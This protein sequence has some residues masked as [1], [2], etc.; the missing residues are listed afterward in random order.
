MRDMRR[1]SR[2]MNRANQLVSNFGTAIKRRFGFVAD[3]SKPLWYNVKQ[4]IGE[5]TT[6]YFI[7]PSNMACHVRLRDHPTPKGTQSLLGLGLNYCIKEKINTTTE[8]T[9]TR[10][11]EDVRRIFHL[12]GTEDDGDYIKSLYIKSDYKFDEASEDIEQAL[13]NFE[14]AV[15]NDKQQTKQRRKVY[16][17]LTPYH[18]DLI[19]SLRNHDDYIIV[20]ADKNLGPCLLDRQ[21]YIERGCSEHLGNPTNYQEITEQQVFTRMAGLKYKLFH[22]LSEF[23]SKPILEKRQGKTPSV[24]AISKAE[25]T[26]LLRAIKKF[27]EKLARFRMTLKI[28]KIPWKTRPIVCCAGTWMNAWSKWLDYWLQ[29]LKPFVPTYTRDSQQLLDELRELDLPPNAILSTADA[30]AMYNNIDTEHAIQVITWWLD[31]LQPDL[32]QGFPIEAVKFAMEVIMRNN[33]FEWGDLYFL[34][35]LGTAMGT[36]AAVMWATLYYGY[37]EVHTL[38]PRYNNN[39]FYFRRFIDDIFLIWLRD[40]TDAWANFCSD[41]NNFGILTWDIDEQSTS[42]NFLD[43]TLTIV[44]GKIESRTYQKAMNL[45]LYLPPS[46]AHSENVLK[47]TVYGLIRRYYLQNTH[48]SDYIYFVRLLFRRLL[49]RG[50][51]REYIYS[52]ILEVC[53]KLESRDKQNLMLESTTQPDNEDEMLFLHFV[54]HPDDISRLSIRQHYNKHCQQLFKAELGVE[55]P[56]IAY[57]RPRNL[58]DILTQ[59]KLYQAPGKTASTTMGKYK[60]G[61]AP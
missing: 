9:F 56:T 60:Q 10:L 49:T 6:S 61:L 8:H 39:L 29:K 11:R 55:R 34:Q 50:W 41:V 43:L 42:V 35:L 57:S 14:E 3:P 23:Y 40:G 31:E 24:I 17:N 28:H 37:H 22:F 45:Y 18:W 54:F 32:P 16:S 36:S 27:G 1:T 44:D 48:R 58:G 4:R 59:A 21:V 53:N 20:E 13:N 51:N 25:H 19:E 47:G 2:H 15:L 7:Q 5:L 38:I 26:Y 12:R 33:I 46:S 52:L 30:N